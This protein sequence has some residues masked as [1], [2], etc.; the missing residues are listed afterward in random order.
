[1]GRIPELFPLYRDSKCVCQET[2]HRI[3]FF[4]GLLLLVPV[5]LFQTLC[6]AML[7][8]ICG[9]NILSHHFMLHL[10]L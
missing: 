7:L 5:F 1:D 8:W 10:F 6:R 2:N 4:A 9:R 3:Y